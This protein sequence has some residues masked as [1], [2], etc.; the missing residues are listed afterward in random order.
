[1]AELRMF[2]QFLFPSFQAIRECAFTDF[3]IFLLN[4]SKQN[5]FIRKS[6]RYKKKFRK[7][8]K[9]NV[10]IISSQLESKI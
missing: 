10:K 1:M 7:F 2:E 3:Q 9:H 6:K 8:E 4:P 5:E